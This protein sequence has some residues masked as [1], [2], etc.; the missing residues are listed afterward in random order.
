MSPN[1]LDPQ[2]LDTILE[3]VSTSRT[4]RRRVEKR[5]RKVK[6]AKHGKRY[7]TI[8]EPVILLNMDGTPARNSETNETIEE[9]HVGF[10][11]IRLADPAFV[12][13][14]PQD[15][16]TVRWTLTMIEA[17][18]T[19]RTALKDLKPG[20]VLELGEEEWALLKRATEKGT[21]GLGGDSCLEY[22]YSIIHA[23]VTDP[24]KAPKKPAEEAEESESASQ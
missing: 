13:D 24:R 19:I 1:P 15:P 23:P 7:I 22:A 17:R 3:Q 8:L 11:R 6:M 12:T 14:T 10:I 4:M 2:T 21:Y 5:L 18:M 16:S 9:T 20:D